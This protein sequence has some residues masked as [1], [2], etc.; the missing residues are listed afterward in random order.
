METRRG[1][2]RQKQKMTLKPATTSDKWRE[3]SFTVTTSNLTDV[4]RTT[5]TNLDVLQD[6]RIDDCWNVDVDR[7]LSDSWT[8]FTKFFLL[9][10]NLPKVNMWSGERLAKIQATTKLDYFAA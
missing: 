9:K 5:H 7:S 8:E 4:T 6:K 10:R 2:N 1:L 3:T